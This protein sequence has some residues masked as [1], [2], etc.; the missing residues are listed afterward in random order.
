MI[1]VHLDWYRPL[2]ELK[3][4]LDGSSKHPD[5]M[6]Q[7]SRPD[8]ETVQYRIENLENPV[9]LH[10]ANCTSDEDLFRFVKRFGMTAWYAD[11]QVLDRMPM[12][13]LRFIHEQIV[14]IFEVLSLS[15]IDERID[16]LDANELFR[17]SSFSP[18]F[19]RLSGDG[20]SRLIMRPSSLDDLMIMEGA[21]AADEGAIALR[22]AHCQRLFLI[23]PLTGRRSHA[24]YCS[25][26][27]RVAAMR[28]RKASKETWQ[29]GF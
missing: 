23:G 8:V 13:S 28:A 3:L 26:R 5:G 14:Q 11:A 20:R 21:I 17:W 25:D 6:L 7:S 12:G 4:V 27:C 29:E 24:V 9:S 1:P 19:E 18:R 22:C 16:R 10:L 15:N 2:G